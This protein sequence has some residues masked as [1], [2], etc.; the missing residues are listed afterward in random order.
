M[1]LPRQNFKKYINFYCEK[2]ILVDMMELPDPMRKSVADSSSLCLE[3]ILIY[4]WA[5][6]Y[7]FTEQTC[8]H[9]HI[10]HM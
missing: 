1:F 4:A 7:S 5:L 10:L 6:S 3:R 8:T 9:I 2:Y